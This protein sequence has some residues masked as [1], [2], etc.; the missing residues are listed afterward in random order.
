MIGVLESAL[1]FLLLIALLFLGLH[2]ATAMFLVG[3]LG[4]ALYLGPARW[5]TMSCS[6]SRFTSC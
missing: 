6:P 3:L 2:V 4:A 1:G 5:R